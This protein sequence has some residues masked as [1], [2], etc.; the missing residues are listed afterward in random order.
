M[1]DFSEYSQSELLAEL[2]ERLERIKEFRK[3][4]KI[5]YF[6]PMTYQK[7]FMDAGSKYKVRYLRA[8][9][10]T[11]KTYG[12][13]AEFSYHLTGLYPEWWGG[14]RIT[15]GGHTY[16][17][18]GVTLDSVKNVLQKEL[19]GTND[20]KNSDSIGTG[21]IPK[22]CIDIESV[23]RDG[24]RL[25]SVKIKHVSGDDNYLMF[26]GSENESVMFGQKVVGVWC[27]EEP[28]YRSK[29]IFGQVVTRTLNAL[30]N[31]ENGFVIYTATPEHGQTALNDLFNNSQDPDNESYGSLYLQFACMDDNIHMTKEQIEEYLKAVPEYQREMRRKG[32]PFIGEGHIFSTDEFTIHPD[33]SFYPSDSFE[34]LG[35]VDWGVSK[36]PT[37]L[38]IG[39]RNPDTNEIT[40]TNEFYFDKDEYDRSAERLGKFILESE[41]AAVPIVV[42]HDKPQYATVL[43]RMGCNTGPHM[44]FK[45]PHE[46][47]LNIKHLN[48]ANNKSVRDVETGLHEMVYLF[49]QGLLKVSPS[50]WHWYKEKRSYYWKYNDTTKVSS[51]SKG[52][53]HCIDA[54]RYLTMS[55]IA[56]KGGKWCNRGDVTTTAMQSFDTVQFN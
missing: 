27:D 49:N 2:Q 56:N 22:Q 55:L 38:M 45:N 10:R 48:S 34:V 1:I 15:T 52:N 17:A 54:S 7:E 50:C 23:S 53:E 20:A 14:E 9:N 39:V 25:K 5:E 21:S 31:G 42:P 28:P 33:N 37:V 4:N 19:I 32:I 8:G 13:A 18:V 43:Q 47:Q 6:E 16:W 30:G 51:P 36:D 24:A 12:T 35:A 40:I 29:E 26:Y 3:F 44:L 11:G 46:T 41:F